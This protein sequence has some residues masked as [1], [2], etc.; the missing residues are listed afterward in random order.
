MD[1]AANEMAGLRISA[2]HACRPGGR[3]GPR[4]SGG[5]NMRCSTA[6]S[7]DWH[8]RGKTNRKH[9]PWR[10]A[11]CSCRSCAATAAGLL[12]A[13]CAWRAA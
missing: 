5:E 13:T 10:A 4:A 9:T 3:C 7:W 12:T 11:V 6:G 8:S 1:D 2:V